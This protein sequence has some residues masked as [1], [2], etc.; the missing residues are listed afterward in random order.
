MRQ[1]RLLASAALHGPRSSLR[2]RHSERT[3]CNDINAF[4]TVSWLI[5]VADELE[6]EVLKGMGSTHAFRKAVSFWTAS[7]LTVPSGFFRMC[8]M[9]VGLRFNQDISGRSVVVVVKK[10]AL[11]RSSVPTFSSFRMQESGLTGGNSSSPA[12]KPTGSAM[13]CA[14]LEA[15]MTRP[16]STF[17]HS[18]PRQPSRGSLRPDTAYEMPLS[19]GCSDFS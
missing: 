12:R 5:L 13:V 4:V 16:D 10:Q 11:E 18:Q 8:G 2:S 15:G 19:R 6:L 14:L 3:S 9:L 1:S 7:K 17:P